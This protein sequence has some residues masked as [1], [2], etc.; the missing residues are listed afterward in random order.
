MI[1][2]YELD[3][4]LYAILGKESRCVQI[5]ITGRGINQNVQKSNESNGF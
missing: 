3:E 5:E 2:N 4:N 1:Q